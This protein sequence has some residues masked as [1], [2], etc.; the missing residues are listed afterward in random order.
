M[1][2]FVALG[3]AVCRTLFKAR[4]VATGNGL[5][6]ESGWSRRRTL[7]WSEV[8]EVVFDRR[9]GGLLFRGPNKRANVRISPLMAGLK[10]L[11][12]VMRQHLPPSKYETAAEFLGRVDQLEGGNAFPFMPSVAKK[13]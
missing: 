6:A 2:P 10:P 9:G 1:L 8:S 12:V 3:W 13:K 7:A 11:V 5:I 4:F